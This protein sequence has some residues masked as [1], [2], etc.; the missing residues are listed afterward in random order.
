MM[1]VWLVMISN[2]N[3][4]SD[5]CKRCN[6]T[7]ANSAIRHMQ[8]V[9]S[10]TCNQIAFQ[11]PVESWAIS[12]CWEV[13][14]LQVHNNEV[15]SCENLSHYSLTSWEQ[16]QWFSDYFADNLFQSL[17]SLVGIDSFSWKFISDIW[18]YS[19]QHTDIFFFISAGQIVFFEGPNTNLKQTKATL[20]N[21][22]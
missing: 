4:S 11:N 9:Q 10:D 20:A 14:V 15:W 8:T 16:T 2:L 17:F 6:Q 18:P 1:I 13:L 7:H 3:L 5:T 21:W 19:Q 12:C 22:F